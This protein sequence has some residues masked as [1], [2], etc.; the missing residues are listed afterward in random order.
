M[1]FFKTLA[2]A[3]AVTTIGSVAGAATLTLDPGSVGQTTVSLP[4]NFD[5]T[6][7]TG[8]SVGDD[9]VVYDHNDL[10]G[11]LLSDESWVRYEYL[12]SEAG[13]TNT[14]AE[15]N[16]GGLFSN[17][18]STAIGETVDVLDDGGIVDFL[19]A[20]TTDGES[21]ANGDFASASAG[22]SMA[23]YQESAG[24]FI[25]L[26]GDGFGNNDYDDIAIRIS[27]VPLPAGA[28]L[29]LT[30]LGGFAALRRRKHA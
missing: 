3:A 21:I 15:V 7:T 8:L 24:S 9:V 13:N 17:D 27:A 14:A 28:V 30:G 25:V 16:F 20:D 19:F 12:G 11:L 10:G 22:L 18:G 5:L 4:N 23:F 29:L 1:N 6:A 26:L 2:A